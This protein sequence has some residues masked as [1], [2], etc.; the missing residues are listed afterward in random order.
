MQ[1]TKLILT[2]FKD[3]QKYQRANSELDDIV[4]FLRSPESFAQTGPMKKYFIAMTVI[5]FRVGARGILM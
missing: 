1:R 3:I 2:C 5:L 4:H